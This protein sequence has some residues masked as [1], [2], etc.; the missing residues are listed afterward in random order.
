MLFRSELIDIK[1]RFGDQRRSEIIE[2]QLDLS[3]EDLI[4]EEDV[5]VTLSHN[6]YAKCQP[7]SEYR[8][9]HRGGRGKSSTNVK[10]KDFI[11]RL[12]VA[13]THDTV[14]CFSTRGRLYWLKIY[15]LPQ[16][17]RNG[18]GKPINNLLPL[19]RNERISAF[20]LVREYEDNKS[21]VMASSSGIIKK[22]ALNTFSK[23]RSFGVIAVNLKEDD[24]LIG[25]DITD[26]TK[27]IMLFSDN[28]KATR[29]NENQVRAMGRT[30]RGVIGMRVDKK[31]KVIAM[32]IPEAENEI[33]TVSENGFGKRTP[34]EDYLAKGRGGKGVYAIKLSKRN[35]KMIAA[36][37]VS[38]EDDIMLISNKGV[39]V[40]TRVEEIRSVGRN[41][42][43]VTLIKLDRGEKLVGVCRVLE[44]EDDQDEP[45]V[46]ED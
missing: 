38:P 45:E 27:D 12:M 28:G 33:L 32:I 34:Q 7:I 11:E 31:E 40:R 13:S 16:A 8:A 5:V 6:G 23:P 18:R 9:Q 22:T 1:Q 26:G 44:T 42:Q 24:E 43:G 20:L 30:A 36:C 35:G 4:V 10:S 15:Q 37:Q 46:Q 17:G 19:E 21:I 29:F 25:V 3:L 39:L 2:D 41:T 14:L